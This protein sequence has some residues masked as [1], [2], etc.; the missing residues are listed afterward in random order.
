[1]KTISKFKACCCPRC[2]Q[3]QVVMSLKRMVCVYC[4]KMSQFR[5]QSNWAVKVREFGSA[6]GAALGCLLWKREL[7]P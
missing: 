7:E 5:V 6:R 1:M 3:V 2:G 4:G